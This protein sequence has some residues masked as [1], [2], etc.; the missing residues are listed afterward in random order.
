[1]RWCNGWRLMRFSIIDLQQTP[2]SS[3]KVMLKVFVQPPNTSAPQQYV[4][5]FTSGANARAE[6]DKIRDALSAA[7]NAVKSGP[8]TPTPAGGSTSMAMASAVSKAPGSS[9]PWLD[10]NQLKK[11]AELQQSLLRANPALQRVFM[12]SLRT[13][14]EAVSSGQFV[15]QFWASRVH[16]LRAHAIEKNQARGAYNVLS[17]I[18]PRVEDNVTKLNISKEQIQLI[19]NQ[20]PLV[21][22][23]YDENVPKLSEQE[24][25][26]RFFQSR[27]FKKLRGERVT[28]SDASDAVLD[29]Y[30]RDTGLTSRGAAGH[31]P[32]FIDLEGN[33]EDNSQRLGNRPYFDMRP[34]SMDKV[35][36]IRTLNSMSEKIM[37]N[38]APIDHDPSAPVKEGEDTYKELQL[39]DLRGDEKQERILLNIRDQSRFFAD[40]KDAEMQQSSS[41]T[42][43]D[44]EI[45]LTTLRTDLT[46]TYPRSGATDL[47]KLVEP[48]DDEDEDESD[49]ETTKSEKPR[50]S[51]SKSA[52]TSATTQVL[53]AIRER[54][55]QSESESASSTF[56]LSQSIYD[57]V[58]LTHATT[59]EFLRQFW[60]AFLSGNPDRANEIASL[61]ESLNRALDRVKAVSEEAEA[62][63]QVEVDKLKQHARDVMAA[64]G[65]NIRPNLK[66]VPGGARAVQRLVGPTV[67]ALERARGEYQKAL[68]QQTASLAAPAG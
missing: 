62:E 49:T 60:H 30:L 17:T 35:P 59:T 5:S 33:E 14:P 46:K 2:A 4:F 65:R 66:G 51:G 38:V 52:M 54:K 15:T 16:L 6:A 42:H 31:I 11:D 25:W 43:Q 28:E 18:K 63:R 64:T 29:K 20:H 56:G 24:F 47:Q 37:A 44:P 13:K 67:Q 22:K 3:P 40:T 9:T 61:V 23:V 57:R 45:V 21:K 26:S 39:R 1:M 32:H 10:D 36:I 8:A 12:E 41:F 55:A 7:I 19:F 53:T 48:P 27:L 58:V 68:A 50:I 34:A